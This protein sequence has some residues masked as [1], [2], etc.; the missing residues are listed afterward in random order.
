MTR[1]PGRTTKSRAVE[2]RPASVESRASLRRTLARDTAVQGLR[3][4]DATASAPT[5]GRAG[6]APPVAHAA[7]N[8][9]RRRGG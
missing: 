4:E 8:P 2:Q 7:T 1:T 3:D 5:R 6:A 9:R